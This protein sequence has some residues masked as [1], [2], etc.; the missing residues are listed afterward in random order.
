[1]KICVPSLLCS[2]SI[3]FLLFYSTSS[4]YPLNQAISLQHSKKKEKVERKICVR[5]MTRPNIAI[6]PSKPIPGETSS[7][8]WPPPVF[9][10]HFRGIIRWIFGSSRVVRIVASEQF[11]KLCFLFLDFSAALS[12]IFGR[13][14]FRWSSFSCLSQLWI[15][16]ELGQ[17]TGAESVSISAVIGIPESV[18]SGVCLLSY[19]QI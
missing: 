12:C 4:A 1:M 10:K 11:V 15:S 14:L 5:S 16:V 17:A 6:K 13:M 3:F 8:V 9:S 19:T 2:L 18:R 7:C